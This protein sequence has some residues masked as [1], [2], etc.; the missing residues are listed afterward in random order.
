MSKDQYYSREDQPT[1]EPKRW[2][3]DRAPRPL[4]DQPD[5]ATP[6]PKC[7]NVTMSPISDV[8]I[9]CSTCGHTETLQ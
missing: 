2:K 8:E 4:F 6:C 7:G 9:V 1:P 3:K 5:E